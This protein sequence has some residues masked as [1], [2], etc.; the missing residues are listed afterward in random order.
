MIERDLEP[1][2]LLNEGMGRMIQPP[3]RILAHRRLRCR[4]DPQNRRSTRKKRTAHA[5]RLPSRFALTTCDGPQTTTG[6]P[7]RTMISRRF[8]GV[9]FFR[10]AVII[11][12]TSLDFCYARAHCWRYNEGLVATS[13]IAPTTK[14]HSNRPLV[15][16]FESGVG[17]GLCSLVSVVRSSRRTSRFCGK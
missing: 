5:K 11:D 17:D 10:L 2:D 7:A 6:R 12:E 8:P 15:R 1:Q 9:R 16:R 13:Q 14:L 3:H 4:T